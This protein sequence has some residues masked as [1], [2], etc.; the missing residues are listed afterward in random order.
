MTTQSI[1][2]KFPK[3]EDYLIEI[4]LALQAKQATQ[5][6]SESV[7]QEVATY[8]NIPE[9]RVSSVMSFYT[10][11]STKPRGQ[12]IIQIC[13]DVLCMVQDT[14]SVHDVLQKVLGITFDETTEDKMFTIEHSSCLGHCE[15]APVMRINEKTYTN[16]TPNKIKAIIAE[17]RGKSS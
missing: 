3:Q 13:E 7:L 1:L 15:Q 6:L 16:L 2:K 8:L 9:S 11:L 17:Y 12:Y 4:L 5:S 10:M 14:F